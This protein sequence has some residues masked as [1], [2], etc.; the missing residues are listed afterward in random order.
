MHSPRRTALLFALAALLIAAPR[1][2][3]SAT[4]C[5]NDLLE[6]VEAASAA[7]AASMEGAA[8]SAPAP[9]AAR[10]FSGGI[11][12]RPEAARSGARKASPASV[13]YRIH[14]CR[15]AAGADAFPVEEVRAAMAH[16]AEE[17]A[18]GAI[19]LEEEAL[20]RFD[21]DDCD[22]VLGDASWSDPL[23]AN[24]PDGVLTVA[25]VR[26]ITN[27]GGDFTVGGFCRFF[28][29][30]CVNAATV[31]TLVV[32]EL[33]H[34]FGL[35]HTFECASGRETEG[36]CAT[37]GDFLCDTPADRGPK[38]MKG[39]ARC[40]DG[41][42]LDG[43]CS[44]SCSSKS[45]TDGSRPDGLNWMSFY[46]CSPGRFSDGQRDFMRCTLEHELA[47]Y[48]ASGPATTTSTTTSSTSTTTL[49]PAGPACGD[50]NAD[51][52]VTASDALAILRA[53]VGLAAC[54]RW[55]CDYD[56]SG[57]VSAADALRVLRA[58]IGGNEPPLCPP[59]STD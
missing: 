38:A 28:G 49:S 15:D 55:Q 59:A 19:A 31:D 2:D 42:L 30:L 24:T 25:W 39:I 40:D 48:N 11:A 34:F 47:A 18:G 51:G 41:K 45:C 3:A 36:D 26:T 6:A 54:P 56:G 52:D 10:I 27:P 20:V 46:D 57:G 44:G 21:D 22:V 43:S 4:S 17:F 13:R 33:G 8:G 12:C 9:G 1:A 16:A 35:A 23:V 58:A 29:P 53:S 32:H 7:T 50:A 5:G 37:T 14:L